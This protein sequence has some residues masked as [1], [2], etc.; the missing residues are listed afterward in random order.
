MS[1]IT[2]FFGS[3]KSEVVTIQP[4]S[5]F[6]IPILRS[7]T[8]TNINI[9]NEVYEYAQEKRR[10]LSQKIEDQRLEYENYVFLTM[11]GFESCKNVK[12]FWNYKYERMVELLKMFS[13]NDKSYLD[14]F[15]TLLKDDT[16]S[17]C[18]EKKLTI[19][20]KEK[21]TEK[22]SDENIQKLKVTLDSVQKNIDI[23]DF[24]QIEK[25]ISSDFYKYEKDNIDVKHQKYIKENLKEFLNNKY[26]VKH[27]YDTY[28]L[29]Y[30]PIYVAENEDRTEGF[31]YIE[32]YKDLY[33]VLFEWNDNT[34]KA[35]NFQEYVE[36]N[37]VDVE[38]KN[39][40]T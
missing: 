15:P 2:K 39:L 5:K 33:T 24:F 14:R 26:G 18:K 19:F 25:L 9:S 10:S 8:Y 31:Y 40:L 4:P 3:G 17:Y 20:N 34:D 23:F 29:L 22:I 27:D 28:R 13:K 12:S 7:N 30:K 32:I 16:E 37:K 1:I 6:N 21:Y 11:V 35:L 36:Q 38:P